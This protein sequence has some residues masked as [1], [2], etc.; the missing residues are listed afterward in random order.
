MALAPTFVV[1]IGK[2]PDG[3][4][5]TMNVVRSWLDHHK[6]QS[7]SFKPVADYDGSMGFDIGFISEAEAQLFRIALFDLSSA[8]EREGDQ[9]LGT[10]YYLIHRLVRRT[11]L[12]TAIFHSHRRKTRW[13]TLV[14]LSL[15]VSLVIS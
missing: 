5:E 4:G 14:H 8:A 2:Q 9:V 13:R 12:N 1:H 6:I 3:F 7:A 15:Q 11:P 10:G